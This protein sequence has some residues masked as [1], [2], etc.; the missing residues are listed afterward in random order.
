M[1]DPSV[2]TFGEAFKSIRSWPDSWPD[3]LEEL[4]QND[5]LFETKILE[6]SWG[7]VDALGESD[8]KLGEIFERVPLDA[9]LFEMGFTAPIVNI[10]LRDGLIKSRDLLALSLVQFQKLRN[11]GP[12]KNQPLV[13]TLV[14]QQIS[15]LTYAQN[16][17]FFSAENDSEI[18]S[19]EFEVAQE[20]NSAL[21][22]A[23][24]PHHDDERTGRLMSELQ[25]LAIYM[26]HIGAGNESI[27][28]FV[29]KSDLKA[30]EAFA[31]LF[32]VTA[33][34]ISN[35]SEYL[36]PVASLTN[37][38]ASLSSQETHV[39][40]SRIARKDTK[41]LDKI[42]EELGLTRERIRQIEVKI[43]RS[44]SEFV[45]MD[46]NFSL[47]LEALNSR[48]AEPLL[49]RQLFSFFG[50]L[51]QTVLP[52]ATFADLL[53]GFGSIQRDSDWYMSDQDAV[54]ELFDQLAGDT[55]DARVLLAEAMLND[56]ADYWPSMT[57]KLFPRWMKHKGYDSVMSYWVKSPK[58]LDYA[59]V[60]LMQSNQPLT[61][62]GIVSRANQELNI[63]SL[64]NALAAS[65]NFVKTGKKDW[66][67]ASWSM[68]AYG[69]IKE[70]IG[71][72]VDAEGSI[73]FDQLALR[74]EPFGVKVASIYAYAS[75]PPFVIAHGLVRRSAYQ[76]VIRKTLQDTKNLY[77][78]ADGVQLRVTINDEHL[79]G[80]GS[81]CPVA[82]AAELGVPT[83]G[84]VQ[85]NSAYGVF[86]VSSRGSQ[87]F[88][89]S[90]RKVAEGLNVT[91]GEQMLMHFENGRVW[92]A[93]F[94]VESEE[95]EWLREVLDLKHGQTPLDA[96]SWALS[97]TFLLSKS[98]CLEILEKRQETD[99]H[100][101]VEKFTL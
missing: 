34:S 54:S 98:Q 8:T 63:R 55:G 52:E 81:P 76:K 2:P 101:V 51:S 59:E 67:L 64:E 25:K 96:I 44:Y 32:S 31:D 53:V 42:G 65:D 78:M 11:S 24:Y 19:N 83:E 56:L 38:L 12:A 60:A 88:L 72:I 97:K 71:K 27:L 49:E 15:S 21:E 50:E 99:L 62:E 14:R 77:Y 58:I 9:N 86:S 90:I 17:H 89:P 35:V 66:S 5:A 7:I 69:T 87:Y 1:T 95:G 80:S 91:S 92:F 85:F 37:F 33:R 73:P 93:K 28:E 47:F 23:S 36:T 39:A 61:A 6:I 22:S 70:E 16:K 43:R 57:E 79:R 100:A 48:L 68:P 3:K 30:N 29:S 46:A 74:L 20:I 82:L 13:L 75:S 41:T 10:L 84:K 94:D 18:Y 45:S 4:N 40:N 26:E